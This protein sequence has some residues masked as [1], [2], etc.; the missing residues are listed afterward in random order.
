MNKVEELIARINEKKF[1]G[2]VGLDPTVKVV[3]GKVVSWLERGVYADAILYDF[4][5]DIIDTIYDIVPAVKPNIA[6]FERYLAYN[7][8]HEVCQ[9]AKMKGL[10]VIADVKREDIGNTA[11]AYADAYLTRDYIDFVTLSPYLGTD[12]IKPFLDVAV[13]Y[14]KGVF[15]LAKTSNVSACEFQNLAFAYNS[16]TFH[17]VYRYVMDKIVEWNVYCGDANGYGRVGAVVGATYPIQA[18]KLRHEYPNIFFLVP[19]YGAQGAGAEDVKVNFDKN[20]EGAI[21]NSSRGIIG[22]H[23][24][25]EKDFRTATREAVLEMKKD[26]SCCIGTGV[27]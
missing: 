16:P 9:Y 4:C 5:K 23:L 2:V 19:G 10:F 11:E 8:F 6:F 14:N 20:G 22:A 15:V 18:E 26:L 3:Q 25:S 1:P 7:T 13:K 17:S 21:V 12:S 24:K 27:Q